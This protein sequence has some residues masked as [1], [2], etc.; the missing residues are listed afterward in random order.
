[1]T[2]PTTSTEIKRIIKEFK[3]GKAPGFSGINKVLLMNLPD[4]A[5]DRFRDIVTLTLSMG[6]FPIVFKNGLI[7]LILKQ[8]KD[9]KD[10]NNYRPLPS[11]RCLAKS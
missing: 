5:I 2:R 10:P 7:I 6:Y 9:P 1:M 4:I 11:R 3:N 8:G